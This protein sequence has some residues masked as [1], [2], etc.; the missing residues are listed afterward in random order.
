MQTEPGKRHNPLLPCAVKLKPPG[1][2]VRRSSYTF[3]TATM[4]IALVASGCGSSSNSGN[5]A[6][7]TPSGAATVSSQRTV[8]TTTGA[9]TSL[10]ALIPTPANTS[11]TDG[12]D[13]LADEGVHTHFLVNG[14]PNDVMTAY[15]TALEGQGWAVT[16]ESS[17]GSGG[18]GGATYTGTNGGAFGVFTGGGYG[19]ATDIDACAWPAKHSTDKCGHGTGR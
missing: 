8:T 10:Q 18:G 11:R 17:G 9:N 6:S 3:A 2:R 16:V 1:G 7:S 19:S 4:A 13:A 5:T 12:P 15:K 14:P